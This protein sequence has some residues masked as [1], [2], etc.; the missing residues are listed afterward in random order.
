M[1]DAI[2]REGRIIVLTELFY[3]KGAMFFLK[4]RRNIFQNHATVW[5]FLHLKYKS[6]EPWNVLKIVVSTT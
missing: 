6:I 4:N 5:S 1:D 2:E 3:I